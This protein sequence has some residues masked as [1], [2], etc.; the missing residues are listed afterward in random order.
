V[1]EVV[2]WYADSYCSQKDSP[3]D[4]SYE[5]LQGALK[6]TFGLEAS[7]QELRA[8]P[9]N[10]LMAK[11]A[12]RIR[13]RFEERERL[14]GAER[15]LFHQRMIMLQIVDTQWKDHLYSLD[16]LKEGIGLRGY[17]QR[18]PLVEY[19]KESYEMFQALMDRIDEEILRWSF[20]YQPV[21][22]PPPPPVAEEAERPIHARAAPRPKEPELAGVGVKTVPRNLSF[23]NP[24]ESPSAFARAAQPREASG[25]TNEVQTVRREGPKVGRNDPC[26]CGSGKKYKKCHGS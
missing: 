4:W 24:S 10:D 8:I 6:E 21:E 23:N 13:A 2:E 19:K 3:S 26:P 18:D 25:G 16:H 17:G 9:R 5:S 14:I 15:M 7:L 11:L 22:A 1:D 20:L 12:G